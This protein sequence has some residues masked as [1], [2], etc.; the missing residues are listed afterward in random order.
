ML[1]KVNSESKSHE[2][3]VSHV[4]TESMCQRSAR[5]DILILEK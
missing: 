2:P 1:G 5:S 3:C 4:S